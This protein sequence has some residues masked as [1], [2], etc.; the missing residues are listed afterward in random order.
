MNHKSKFLAISM[1]AVLILFSSF[2]AMASEP[3]MTMINEEDGIYQLSTRAVQEEDQSLVNQ[4]GKVYIHLQDDYY[5]EAKKTTITRSDSLNQ[6]RPETQDVIKNIF[7]AADSGKMVLDGPIEV[8]TPQNVDKIVTSIL[9]NRAAAYPVTNEQIRYNTIE[10][11]EVVDA[12]SDEFAAST[13]EF[14]ENLADVIIGGIADAI[15][16]VAGA[17]HTIAGFFPNKYSTVKA[18]KDWTLDIQLQE[19]K[20]VQLSWVY[21]NNS[22][23]LGA[24]TQF[25]TIRYNSRLSSGLHAPVNDT[26]AYSYYRTPNYQSPENIARQNYN[27]TWVERIEEYPILDYTFPSY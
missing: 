23:Y 6:F 4:N 13:D 2:T 25:S 3:K 19:E 9:M 24:Q 1:S 18:Y 14:F 11:P 8:Y 26:Y 22:P 17:I 16:P 5:A 27:D 15:S 10:G 21:I 7:A 20:V 12:G